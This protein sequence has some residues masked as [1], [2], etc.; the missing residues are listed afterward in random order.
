MVRGDPVTRDESLG[1][2]KTDL[3]TTHESVQMILENVLAV[4]VS[5]RVIIQLGPQVANRVAPAK[6]ER[7]EMV[8]LILPGGVMSDAVFR[9]DLVLLGLGNV[10]HAGRIT[11]PTDR[12][13]GYMER[14]ARRHPKI[15]QRLA[16]RVTKTSNGRER[17]RRERQADCYHRCCGYSDCALHTCLLEPGCSHHGPY[18]KKSEG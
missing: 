9:V 17:C 14:H 16:V 10:A 7:D 1:T 11:G 8:D 5:V 13:N 12:R 3:A 6:F 15:I 18:G 2:T 4:E